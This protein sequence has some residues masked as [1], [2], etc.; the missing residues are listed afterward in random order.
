ME[1]GLLPPF[2]TG[3]H[4]GIPGMSIDEVVDEQGLKTV[5]VLVGGSKRQDWDE[6]FGPLNFL[7]FVGHNQD[8]PGKPGFLFA[9]LRLVS[10]IH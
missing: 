1:A 6:T 9:V 8:F 7:P 4:E 5:G 10:G 2:Y 3:C